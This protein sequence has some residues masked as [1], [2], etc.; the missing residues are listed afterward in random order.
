MKLRSVGDSSHSSSPYEALERHSKARLY[1]NCVLRF[2]ARPTRPSGTPPRRGFCLIAAGW[3]GPLRGGVA[4]MSRRSTKCGNG[5]P[6]WVRSAG[7]D[8]AP[9]SFITLKPVAPG[10]IAMPRHVLRQRISLALTCLFI[11]HDTSLTGN[12]QA[13]L[14]YGPRDIRMESMADPVPGSGEV[15]VQVGGCGIC[16]GDYSGHKPGAAKL[17]GLQEPSIRGHEIAGTV[18]DCGQ[19]VEGLPIGSKVAVS[20]S[21]PCGRCLPCQK[22]MPHL[23]ENRKP[24]ALH[25]GGGFAEYSSVLPEQCYL[26]PEGTTLIEAAVTEPLPLPAVFIRRAV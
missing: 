11:G 9:C 2:N 19:G 26:I 8:S 23:C 12:M 6:G 25:Q 13:A 24:R 7:G 17:A 18:V 21:R 16:G 10:Y 15:V 20:P 3:D 14:T 1:W 4:D 22:G 5:R